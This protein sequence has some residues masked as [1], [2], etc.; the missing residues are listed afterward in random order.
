MVLEWLRRG[1]AKL[2]QHL[3]T[4]LFTKGALRKVYLTAT[5]QCAAPADAKL[6]ACRLKIQPS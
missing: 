4:Y 2:S 1:D 5:D 6:P 3:K